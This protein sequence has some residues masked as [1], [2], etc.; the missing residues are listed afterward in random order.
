MSDKLKTLIPTDFSVQADYA[1]LMVKN[2]ERKA[3]LEVTF[4]HVLNV[5]DTVSIDVN[6]MIETCGEI[7]NEYV[8]SQK[9]IAE[10]KLNSIK[11]I[12][13]NHIHTA[14]VYGKTTHEI[15]DY[16]EQNQFD[17]IVMGTKGLS[18]LRERI[19][20]SEAQIIAR[21]S[22]VPLLTLMCDRSDL[23]IQHLLLVHNFNDTH[24][25]DLSLMKKFSVIFGAK[26]HLLQI[27]NK[28]IDSVRG[29]IEANMEKFARINEVE[30]YEMHIV[31]DSDIEA[32]VIHF[33]Q[34]SNMDIVCIGTHGKGGFFHTSAAEKLVNHM[35]KPIITF[36]LN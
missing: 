8:I 34:M 36:H 5:P 1:F 32:G 2:L 13:G 14:L 10:Q 29:E 15:I 28:P 11:M 25:Q 23:E 3:N 24:K 17:L 31:K 20:G 27:T 21:K 30:D 26:L 6:G 9:N 16:A 4:L 33:N 12:H 22:S 19:A 18:G 7:D 35:Y